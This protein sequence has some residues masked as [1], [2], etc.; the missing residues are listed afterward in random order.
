MY[1]SKLLPNYSFKTLRWNSSLYK[2][3]LTIDSELTAAWRTQSK[4]PCH[5]HIN[6]GWADMNIFPCEDSFSRILTQGVMST[7][8]NLISFFFLNWQWITGE[9]F[10][11]AHE[12][13]I[14]CLIM[15]QPTQRVTGGTFIYIFEPR[16]TKQHTPSVFVQNQL[17]ES[18][19]CDECS[20]G[21][22]HINK[23]ETT[24]WECL[25]IAW[26]RRALVSFHP[27]SH[28]IS[29]ACAERDAYGSTGWLFKGLQDWQVYSPSK[30][31]GIVSLS[32]APEPPAGSEPRQANF[33][34]PE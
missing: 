3:T 23:A 5:S 34:K 33:L 18:L 32:T 6:V 13:K 11:F 10:E 9:I 22:T 24:R 4:A 25:H 28:Q 31:G 19:R 14:T 17:H 29:V 26:W 7:I 27:G 20:V 16:K 15:S 8:T 1:F 21:C 2:I 12:K 30:C